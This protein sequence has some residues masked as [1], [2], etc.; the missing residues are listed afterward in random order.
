MYSLSVM[1]LTAALIVGGGG[2]PYS[3]CNMVSMVGYSRDV[4]FLNAALCSF[5]V[6][7]RRF[8]SSHVAH[9][10]IRFL[11]RAFPFGGQTDHLHQC[12]TA[13]SLQRL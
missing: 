2:M 10:G 9:Y 8:G 7:G 4:P 5:C 6:D 12:P 3:K 11:C 1:M 13:R